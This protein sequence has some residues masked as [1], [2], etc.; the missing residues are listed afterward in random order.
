MAEPLE[1]RTP[2][3]LCISSST[4]LRLALS[5]ADMLDLDNILDVS[6]SDFMFHFHHGNHEAKACLVDVGQPR[7]YALDALASRYPKPLMCPYKHYFSNGH[8]ETRAISNINTSK[9]KEGPVLLVKY[10]VSEKSGYIT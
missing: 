1:P 4:F 7:A 6:L 3:S 2:G 5:E 9:K 10:S 8:S